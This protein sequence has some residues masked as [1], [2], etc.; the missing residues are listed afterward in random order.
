MNSVFLAL[1]KISFLLVIIGFC[2]PIAYGLNGFQLANNDIA[3]SGLSFALYGLFVSAVIGL[4][5]YFLNNLG[6]EIDALDIL[7]MIT[8]SK[9]ITLSVN[10]SCI[11]FGLIPFFINLKEHGGNYQ[12]GIIL[13]LIGFA[14]TLIFHIVSYIVEYLEGG[15]GGGSGNSG[16]SGGSGSSSSSSSSGS[17]SSSDDDYYFPD[18]CP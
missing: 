12:Y 16:Y 7:W 13:I 17:G 10:I 1:A 8:E 3:S 18:V 4:L 11:C 5:F 2:L 14:L 6:L 15:R 9:I